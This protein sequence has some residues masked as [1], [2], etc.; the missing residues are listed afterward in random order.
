M[1]ACVINRIL[2][3]FNYLTF[4]T[5]INAKRVETTLSSVQDWGIKVNYVRIHTF[6]VDWPHDR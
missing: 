2:F 4:Q 6:I 5:E 1:A 3:P